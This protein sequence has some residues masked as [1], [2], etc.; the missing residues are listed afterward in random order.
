MLMSVQPTEPIFTGSWCGWWLFGG[1]MPVICARRAGFRTE[2]ENLRCRL[3][4]MR[5][6][7]P[8]LNKPFCVMYLKISECWNL[9]ASTCL[10]AA[11][12]HSSSDRISGCEGNCLLLG[13]GT[14][15]KWDLGMDNGKKG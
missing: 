7:K 10:A 8:L 14:C 4:S 15:R 13:S 9:L 12:R 11:S 5:E 3:V 1:M 6:G 2:G